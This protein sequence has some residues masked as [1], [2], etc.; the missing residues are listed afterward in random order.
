MRQFYVLFTVMALFPSGIR[1]QQDFHYPLKDHFETV[2]SGGPELIQIPNN[3]GYYGSFVIRDV[4][5]Y[6]CGQASTASGYFFED[7]AGLQFNDPPGFIGQEYSLAFN[8]QIDEF[9]S[10]PGWVRLLSFTHTDD[11]G[12]Y[13]KLT[14]PPTN[15]TLEFWPNG[16]VG[17]WDFF[18]P[19]T[20]YQLILVRSADGLIK[21]F[22]NGLEFSQYD[23]S[24]TQAYVP[25]DPTQYIM[26]FRD[27][28]SVLADEASPG[29]VSH[30]RITNTAWNAEQIQ[31]VWEEFCSSLLNISEPAD[32][33]FRI[34]PNPACD[35]VYITNP[36]LSGPYRVTL[37]DMTGKLAFAEEFPGSD[38]RID[39]SGLCQG[40][41]LLRAWDENKAVAIK[42]IRQ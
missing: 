14:N 39:L 35:W 25:Q 36:G 10:P 23:D 28:P 27:H 17:E 5:E 42:L 16:T 24:G 34:K 31:A 11:V 38:C 1:C 7:D 12:I 29:F 15:G 41:Y 22:I 19:E 6:I 21:I 8:F 32:Q 4:P 9:I 2:P 40:I 26:F 20:F 3:S 30:I 33:T 37:C 18:N 13:I